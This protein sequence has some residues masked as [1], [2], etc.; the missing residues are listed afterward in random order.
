MCRRRQHG[1]SSRFGY[2][3]CCAL[4]H[5]SGLLRGIRGLLFLCLLVWRRVV[6][7]GMQDLADFF[8]EK[9]EH[10]GGNSSK[11][12]GQAPPAFITA[13]VATVSTAI[14]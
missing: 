6:L 3:F 9:T 7:H 8:L 13:T 14:H 10:G 1:F 11:K 2:A 12:W 4:C 5:V